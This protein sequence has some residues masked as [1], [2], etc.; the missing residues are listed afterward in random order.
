MVLY[1][2][3]INDCLQ[4]KNRTSCK[5]KK[6][7][8]KLRKRMLYMVQRWPLHSLQT[9]TPLNKSMNILLYWFVTWVP[10]INFYNDLWCFK[11]SYSYDFWY[12]LIYN[13]NLALSN[14]NFLTIFVSFE[15]HYLVFLKCNES[16][17]KNGSR[18]RLVLCFW[19]GT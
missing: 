6:E 5:K 2:F 15:I 1:S 8:V 11:Y 18:K 16:N 13:L 17:G 19:E 4:F 9:C 3:C 12:I 10:N 14:S 7:T